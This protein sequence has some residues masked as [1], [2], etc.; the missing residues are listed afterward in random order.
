MDAGR[1]L[2]L[3]VATSSATA[4]ATAT[5]LLDGW[6]VMLSSTEGLPLAVTMV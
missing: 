3:S 4:L 2:G 6:R 5:V 1:K